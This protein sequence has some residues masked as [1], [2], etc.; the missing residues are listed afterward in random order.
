MTCADARNALLEADLA[1][2]RGAGTTPLAAHLATCAACRRV[3]ERIVVATDGLHRER[4]GRPR[5]A[6]DAAAAA[7]RGEADRIRHTRRRWLIA[8]PTLAAAGVAAVILARNSDLGLP[9]APSAPPAPAG[10]LAATAAS[11]A[12]A[13]P[14]IVASAARNVAVFTTT[15][16][17]IV[18]VWQF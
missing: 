12:P 18:V 17:N 5:R 3:A 7:A 10:A 14:P 4:I 15:N 1:E 16:P 6:V 8:A 13:T 9:F 11:A 2:L